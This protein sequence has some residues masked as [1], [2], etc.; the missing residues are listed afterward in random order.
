MTAE[1]S[2]E[3]PIRPADGP[4]PTGPAP[5]RAPA[6]VW[7]ALAGA[8][9]LWASAFVG[10]RSALHDFTP[11][12]MALLRFTI[13]SLGLLALWLVSTRLRRERLRLPARR[14]IPL[15]L[16]CA[17]LLIVVYNLGVNFGEQTVSPGTA[18][19]LVGQVPVFSIMLA[20]AI[21]RERV[22]VV[23]WIG[24]GV[25][26]VGTVVMLFADQA[27]LSINIGTVYVLA[28][29]IAESLYFV[30]SKPLLTRY[31]SMEL[32]LYVTIPGTLMMLPFAGDLT[33]QLASAT[34]PNLLIL[35]YLGIFPAAVAYLLWNYALARLDVSASTSGLYALPLITILISFAF[36]HELPSLLGL[37]GGVISLIGAALVNNRR[38]RTARA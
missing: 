34:T 20:A 31:S 24:V 23:G 11:G 6:A 36:L 32:N 5:R 10:I 25:G 18:S 12:P 27:G 13:A 17:L 38:A 16:L 19:F 35:V 8:L 1:H 28:A 26:I 37:V 9:T 29:A 30:L 7:L 22:A 3:R 21:L 14:D 2:T 15:L 4:G 33:H